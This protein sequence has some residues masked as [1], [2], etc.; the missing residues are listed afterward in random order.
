MLMLIW[1]HFFSWS[2]ISTFLFL[3]LFLFLDLMVMCSLDVICSC[4]SII[5][6]VML[7]LR[8]WIY[9]RD[10]R[11]FKISTSLLVWM[12]DVEW[13]SHHQHHDHD[14]LDDDN[15]VSCSVSLP[16][17]R[18]S[19][20]FWIITWLVIVILFSIS[21][22]CEHCQ[23]C[24]VVFNVNWYL[25][26]DSCFGYSLCSF[27]RLIHSVLSLVFCAKTYLIT[28]TIKRQSLKFIF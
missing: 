19:F 18:L 14:H 11:G 9:L 13:W 21:F 7:V 6:M 27:T 1:Y 24:Y 3:L 28:A 8:E 15:N 20:L 17:C 25:L 10:L 4:D 16:V 26:F 2:F 12:L 22:S 5:V 23:C